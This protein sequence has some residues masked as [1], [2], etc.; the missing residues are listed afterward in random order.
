LKERALDSKSA[1]RAEALRLL[2][3]LH[4][5]SLVPFF[6]DRYNKDTSY[7]AQAEALRGF[8]KCGDP[9]AVQFLERASQ[10]KSQG[11]II[12][13]AAEEALDALGK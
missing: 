2:G 7:L 11:N 1:V 8:G 4:N 5:L 12:G 13:L 9:S 10:V 6:E 3:N